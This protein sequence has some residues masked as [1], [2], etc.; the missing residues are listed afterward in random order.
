MRRFFKILLGVL[1]VVASMNVGLTL[2][3]SGAQSLQQELTINGEA[4]PVESV[5]QTPLEGIFAVRLKSGETLYSD[6]E[7]KHFVVGDLFANRE[8]GLVNLTQQ[9]LDHARAERLAEVPREDKVLFRGEQAPEA[10]LKVFTDVTCPYCRKLHEEVPRLNAKGIA[11]EYLAF[12]RSGLKS[13][14]ARLMAQIWCADNPE[15]AMSAA[16]RGEALESSADCDNPVADQY[17][18]GRELNVQG[19]P[20]IVFPDGRMV[21]GYVPAEQLAAMLGIEG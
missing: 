4:V 16:K 11:V 5:K 10:T 2:A 6:A 21:P 13:E 20:A 18:L 12:P 17:H 8:Q 9:A 15:E 7:G 1:L 3:R 19:T 14:G